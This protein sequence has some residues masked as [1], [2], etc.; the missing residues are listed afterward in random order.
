M[1]EKRWL[2]RLGPPVVLVAAI[3]AA[4]SGQ[5]PTPARAAPPATVP[6]A[7]PAPELGVAK[8]AQRPWLAERGDGAWAYGPAG[9]RG[10]RALP[11]DET[12]LAIGARLVASTEP[13]SSGPSPVRLRD[14]RTGKLV[15]TVEP[16]LW[17]SAAV[18]RGD[19]LVVT[20]Y[21]DA[22]ARTDGGIALIRPN[23]PVE[24]LVRGGPFPPEIGV[25]ARGT[26][27]VSPNGRLAASYSCANERCETQVVDLDSRRVFRPTTGTRG[28]LRALTDTDVVLTDGD[29]AWILAL[30]ARTGRERW[31]IRD[32]MLMT[33][34]AGADGSIVGLTGSAS[35]GWAVAKIDSSGNETDVTPRSRD[36][37]FPQVWTQLSTSATA[38]LGTGDFAVALSSPAGAVGDV[39]DVVQ[40][41]IVARR[42][43]VLTGS[44]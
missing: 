27:F 1:V 19:D 11:R 36:G 40:G 30:D 42:V 6:D 17:V 35:R 34:L 15:A 14:W 10:S 4:A 28:F 37:S 38:V 18:F 22:R 23:G 31:R 43:S 44:R 20:G 41:R 32:S 13:F 8:F 3:A 16:G 7:Q 39:F 9:L 25:G 24:M 21:G 2:L 33:P 5:T 29:Y 12:G 26:V